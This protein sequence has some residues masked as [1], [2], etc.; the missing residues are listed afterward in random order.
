MQVPMRSPE[1]IRQQRV[2]VPRLAFRPSRIC[3]SKA[4]LA[5]LLCLASGCA[6]VFSR[7]QNN[8]TDSEAEIPESYC[9]P[10]DVTPLAAPGAAPADALPFP[11]L[12]QAGN[13]PALLV[14]S[15]ATRQIA[16][17]IQVQD[18]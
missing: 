5:L 18:L 3:M 12:P 10:S 8:T 17:V 14:L 7:S 1:S 11:V 9:A 13:D 4:I 6:G 16:Q 2:H 15:P